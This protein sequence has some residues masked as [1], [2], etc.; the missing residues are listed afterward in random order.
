MFFY[1]TNLKQYLI[2]LSHSW[3]RKHDA[4]F[5]FDSNILILIFQF[6]LKYCILF[7]VK[8]FV[9]ISE[10]KQFLSSVKSQEVWQVQNLE[11]F[12]MIFSSQVRSLAF[13][14]LQI[15]NSV[16]SLQVRS[17]AFFSSQI[18]S[19]VSDLQVRSFAFFNSQIINSVL[20]LQVRSFA[21]FYSSVISFVYSDLQILQ[22]LFENESN[23]IF[24]IL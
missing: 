21:F 8:V 20:N 23:H 3:L 12:N 11:I 17:L 9:V 7:F 5:N 18:I 16:F 6:C 2:I 19:S 15:I 13:F 4:V 22:F 10:K 1:V 14:N 24:I